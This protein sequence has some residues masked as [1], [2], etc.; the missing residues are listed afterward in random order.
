MNLQVIKTLKMKTLQTKINMFHN[1]I[2]I[3]KIIKKF[4]DY[5]PQPV[6]KK[7]IRIWL[8]QFP[9]NEDK[10]AALY[11]LSKFRYYSEKDTIS[12]LIDIN[13]RL[14]EQLN[15]N[16]IPPNK[17]IYISVDEPASS[18]HIMLSLIKDNGRLERRGCHFIDSRSVDLITKT[19]ELE[20][21]AIIYIDD[22]SATGNQFS[23]ARQF[24]SSN[25]PL[26]GKFSEF[27]ILLSICEEAYAVIRKLDV[28]IRYSHI[29]SIEERQLHCN[30]TTYN[31]ENRSRLKEVCE[32]ID[33]KF[34]LGYKNMA[35]MVGFYR[36]IPNTT[37]L[38]FRGDLG[39]SKFKGILPR[40]QDL[41]IT[42]QKRKKKGY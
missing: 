25:I 17:V 12:T 7:S 35:T 2:R 38:I 11:L 5:R 8:N 31:D 29:H 16:G 3:Q 34:P 41:P 37:P 1:I 28:D 33:N 40:T 6:T 9:S 30:N 18:S 14:L 23:T 21:G 27:L 15:S 19:I 36:N 4:K 10:K 20:E 26:L 13:E 32:K 24:I 39:Q 22:F 42:I